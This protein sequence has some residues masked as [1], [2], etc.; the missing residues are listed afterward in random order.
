[1]VKRTHLGNVV[2]ASGD[3]TLQGMRGLLD[4]ASKSIVADRQILARIVKNCVPEA[5]RFSIEELEQLI[6]ANLTIGKVPVERDPAA[7]DP[8]VVRQENTED[9]TIREGTVHFDILFTLELPGSK[10]PILLI[11]NVE[12]QNRRD[13][14]YP[15]ERRAEIYAARLVS[16]QGTDYANCSKVY[17]IWLVS[18][19][20]KK[21]EENTIKRYVTAEKLPDGT[22]ADAPEG[23]QISE[24]MFLNLGD[25]GDEKL[26][27]E[28]LRMLDIVFSGNSPEHHARPRVEEKLFAATD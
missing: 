10:S 27:S 4:Q 8:G 17:S 24:V 22:Y 13:L 11:I 6:P 7:A 20:Q 23:A 2:A 26:K 28:F 16:R 5:K 25:P 19:P 21:T 15:L 12:V 3:Q 1:M 14:P 9:G 18:G